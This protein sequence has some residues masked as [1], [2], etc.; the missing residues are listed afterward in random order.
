MRDN[1]NSSRGAAFRLAL[2]A[3]SEI[4]VMRDDTTGS[5]G[6]HLFVPRHRAEA[7]WTTLLDLD[8]TVGEGKR[9]IRPIGWYAFNIARI[10]AGTPLMNVDFGPPHLPH[11]TGLLRQ[12]VSFSTGCY[13]GQEVVARMEN[14]G[15]PKQSLSGLRMTGEA[16]PV[17]GDSVFP[18]DGAEG[19]GVDRC[20]HLKLPQPHVGRGA[21]RI[22]HVARRREW[23]RHGRAD[24]GR[25]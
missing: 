19:G 10:E 23:G 3:D 16:L 15:K 17:A 20:D 13:P 18:S 5:V 14:L 12:R 24:R 7:V 22:R 4:F 1:S 8:A 9:R 21:D 6:L 25:G 2:D 11:E